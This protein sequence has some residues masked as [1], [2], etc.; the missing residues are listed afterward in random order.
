MSSSSVLLMF[1]C[2]LKIGT[3]ALLNP[4][5]CRQCGSDFTEINTFRV[6]LIDKHGQY[7]TV[8]NIQWAT[9]Q[10]LYTNDFV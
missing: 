2:H 9:E 10:C 7:L 8:L 6:H 1:K 4:F 3:H 5:K